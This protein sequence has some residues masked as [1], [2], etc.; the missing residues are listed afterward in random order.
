[1]SRMKRIHLS[2]RARIGIIGVL[3]LAFFVGLL[4]DLRFHGVAW[5]VFYGVTGEESP[6]KQLYGF[7]Q[8]L[9]NWTRRQ[10]DTTVLVAQPGIVSAHGNPHGVNTF[11]DQE[12]EEPKRERQMQMIADAGFGWIRQ[13]FSWADIEIS[14]RGDFVDKRN[15]PKGIDA[16]Q[17]YDN[18]VDLT[19]KYDVQIIARLGKPPQ[20]SEPQAYP[21]D[22]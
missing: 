7:V 10:P 4:L 16:W 14:G 22:R 19:E 5:R 18:I 20:W 13:Q 17:K 6:A 21:A 9:G 3:A 8:Y 12:V 15:D 11:L 2:L 1:M